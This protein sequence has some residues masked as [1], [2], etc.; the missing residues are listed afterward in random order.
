M[1]VAGQAVHAASL[2]QMEKPNSLEALLNKLE[3]NISRIE[4][5]KT[6]PHSAQPHRR[7]AATQSH[8]VQDAAA[9]TRSH[10]P[11]SA[12]TRRKTHEDFEAALLN[13][14]ASAK[15]AS[16]IP[17]ERTAEAKVQAQERA[18]FADEEEDGNEDVQ[19]ISTEGEQ[20]YYEDEEEDLPEEGAG[21]SAPSRPAIPPLPMGAVAARA[22]GLS[23]AMAF[24]EDPDDSPRS[25]PGWG[26]QAPLEPMD[27][28]PTRD[29]IE[30]DRGNL[31]QLPTTKAVWRGAAETDPAPEVFGLTYIPDDEDAPM[32]MT[33]FTKDTPLEFLVSKLGAGPAGSRAIAARALRKRITG[34]EDEASLAARAGA[35]RHLSALASAAGSVL[36][37]AKSGPHSKG[38]P[39][40]RLLN[41]AA[42]AVAA[43]DALQAMSETGGVPMQALVARTTAMPLCTLVAVGGDLVRLSATT[44]L[45]TM[46]CGGSGDARLACCY[47]GAPACLSALWQVGPQEA[48]VAPALLPLPAALQ[49]SHCIR[50]SL[51]LLLVGACAGASR[52]LEYVVIGSLA[53]LGPPVTIDKSLIQGHAAAVLLEMAE[54][55]TCVKAVARTGNG[56]GPLVLMSELAVDHSGGTSGPCG[57]IGRRRCAAAGLARSVQGDD[58]AGGGPG[59]LGTRGLKG[60]DKLA[61]AACPVLAEAFAQ[62]AS[63][64]ENPACSPSEAPSRPRDLTRGCSVQGSLCRRHQAVP[65]HPSRALVQRNLPGGRPQKQHRTGVEGLEGFGCPGNICGSAGQ[66]AYNQEMG[67][68]TVDACEEAQQEI[69]AAQQLLQRLAEH[70]EL[71]QHLLHGVGVLRGPVSGKDVHIDAGEKDGAGRGREW[72]WSMKQGVAQLGTRPIVRPQSARSALQAGFNS[73]AARFPQGS[74]GNTRGLNPTMVSAMSNMAVPGMHTVVNYTGPAVAATVVPALAEVLNGQAHLRQRGVEDVKKDALVL[75]H[76]ILIPSPEMSIEALLPKRPTKGAKFTAATRPHHSVAAALSNKAAIAQAISAHSIIPRLVEL[77]GSKDL[78]HLIHAVGVLRYLP[79][80][81]RSCGEAVFRAAGVKPLLEVAAAGAHLVTTM[82]WADS[83]CAMRSLAGVSAAARAEVFGYQGVGVAAAVLQSVPPVDVA[84]DAAGMLLHLSRAG[85]QAHAEMVAADVAPAVVSLLGH[86]VRDEVGKLEAAQLLG[87][88][89]QESIAR[90]QTV[91]AGAIPAVVH[92]LNHGSPSVRAAA[93]GALSTMAGSPAYAETIVHCDFLPAM[94]KSPVVLAL[95]DMEARRMEGAGEAA[96]ALAALA[97]GGV[98]SQVVVAEARGIDA[99]VELVARG[100][101]LEVRSAAAVTLHTM[102]L[103]GEVDTDALVEAAA[104]KPLVELLRGMWETSSEAGATSATALLAA[105]VCGTLSAVFGEGAAVLCR[106]GRAGWDV[107]G[108]IRSVTISAA[109]PVVDPRMVVRRAGGVK[110]LVRVLGA[111]AEH[112]DEDNLDLMLEEESPSGWQSLAGPRYYAACALQGLAAA[113]SSGQEMVASAGGVKALIRTIRARGPRGGGA[114]LR[115]ACA[116]ALRT[117]VSHTDARRALADVD[118]ATP[119]LAALAVSSAETADCRVCALAVLEKLFRH[120]KPGSASAV[121]ELQPHAVQLVPALVA[122]LPPPGSASALEVPMALARTVLVFAI[123]ATAGGVAATVGAMSKAGETAEARAAIAANADAGVKEGEIVGEEMEVGNTRDGAG[124]AAPELAEAVA[125]DA[126]APT[127]SAPDVLGP[128]P[129]QALLQTVASQ[130]R[131]HLEAVFSEESEPEAE[132]GAGAERSALVDQLWHYH[133][134]ILPLLLPPGMLTKGAGARCARAALR[135]VLRVLERGRHVRETARV[136]FGELL[137]CFAPRHWCTDGQLIIAAGG[138]PYP[139]APPRMDGSGADPRELPSGSTVTEGGQKAALRKRPTSARRKGPIDGYNATSRYSVTMLVGNPDGI[140]PVSVLNVANG[141]LDPVAL[142]DGATDQWET[143][144]RMASVT[145][146]P[147]CCAGDRIGVEL[148]G[149]QGDSWSSEMV[150]RAGVTGQGGGGWGGSLGTSDGSWRTNRVLRSEVPLEV[151]AR[152]GDIMQMRLWFKRPKGATVGGEGGLGGVPIGA[153][154]AGQRSEGQELDGCYIEKVA[155]V[156]SSDAHPTR[157]E[158]KRWEFLCGEWVRGDGRQLRVLPGGVDIGYAETWRETRQ[159]RLR[160]YVNVQTQEQSPNEPLKYFLQHPDNFQ[161]VPTMVVKDWRGRQ[162]PLEESEVAAAVLEEAERGAL[163]SRQYER[164]AAGA[165]TLL[166]VLCV[167]SVPAQ[168]ALW[169]CDGIPRLVTLATVDSGRAAAAG[170]LRVLLASRDR[171]EPW[172]P[173]AYL[174]EFVLAG[175]MHVCRQLACDRRRAE[176]VHSATFF[177]H[178]VAAAGGSYSAIIAACAQVQFVAEML[179]GTGVSMDTK[180]EAAACLRKLSLAPECQHVMYA[181]GAVHALQQVVAEEATKCASVSSILLKGTDAAGAATIGSNA[182]AALQNLGLNS[183]RSY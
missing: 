26:G 57:G 129:D 76:A 158:P 89:S 40:P 75:L 93:A 114:E 172:R 51:S 104:A 126:E 120:W 68:D 144:A 11:A 100:A 80:I 107:S 6:R 35:I 181:A 179:V 169:K 59:R 14:P 36:S 7:R 49:S 156:A 22:G 66:A 111:R 148:V 103:R 71:R 110:A 20:D 176:S 34:R 109:P 182:A 63:N 171:A 12:R 119:I 83:V 32:N 167:S 42:A 118:G 163:T 113:G 97:R 58:G 173:A 79:L 69:F 64:P 16:P 3:S 133:A 94:L 108:G 137:Q 166:E 33:D 121:A 84:A 17:E 124:A 117:L 174:R 30:E 21:P 78:A 128:D 115:G 140:P 43:A 72:Q 54:D 88:L 164:L 53:P 161:V 1:L 96:Q 48:K 91:E 127:P 90:S 38:P 13:R 41:A 139:P 112:L 62:I 25:D 143:L 170:V 134:D 56:V 138:E 24:P 152:L 29:R 136:T 98:A 55:V 151:A 60:G 154:W 122:L 183:T 145:T 9:E 10:R 5:N 28:Q 175:G 99:V 65:C 157:R 116:R 160:C 105:L 141:E 23:P 165:A 19:Y 146:T 18:R 168:A 87:V 82:C 147:V 132:G 159:G 178:K 150:L 52:V 81:E 135:A 4:T 73:T 153:P 131:G 50:G 86:P 162:D 125:A 39:G 149:E 130:V 177:L 47:A 123:V 37:A 142:E 77:A 180:A 45:R 95:V 31:L 2:R 61:A 8:A 15:Q 70:P 101:P 106:A 85:A 102:H 92:Y 74:D 44:A 46:V 155:V 67:G 27:L